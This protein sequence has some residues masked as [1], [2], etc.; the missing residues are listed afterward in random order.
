MP[1]VDTHAHLTD[2]RFDDDRD[3]VLAN[4]RATG[5]ET[6]I[7]IA[8]TL[9]DSEA[10]IALARE[11]TDLLATAGV[12]PHHADQ[13]NEAAARRLRDL[14]T[15]PGVVAIGETGLDYH[16]DTA[17]R[18]TQIEA[19]RAQVRLA[20]DVALPVV[21]HC[22]EAA[23]DV[24]RVLGEEQD[25]SL[26]GVVHC[27]A[28]DLAAAQRLIEGGLHLGIGGLVTFKNAE[29]LRGVLREIGLARIV[30]E[31]DAP[32]LAPV[33]RRGKRNE[34]ALLRHI[35]AKIAEVVG[36]TEDEVACATTDNARALF[37]LPLPRADQ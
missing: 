16:Y 5:V 33:P 7:G 37:N 19:F 2:A 27:F 25:G 12:H 29:R 32:Y 34:P 3:S 26:R 22:R 23:A 9:P 17:P 20:K 31:T 36:V 30:L 11:H 8:D 35:A 18:E 13:W 4:A 15:R 24:L 28:E 10:A 6:V 1:L 21:V 14:A